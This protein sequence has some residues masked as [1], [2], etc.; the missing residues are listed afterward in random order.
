MYSFPDLEPVC[1]FMSSSSCCF[2][3]CIQISQEAGQVVW[4]S[5]LFKNFT[6]FVVIHTD[7]GFGIVKGA[8]IDL[9]LELFCFF[10]VQWML[11]IWSL[12]PLLFPD[13]AWTSGNLQFT[14]YWS[15]AWRI[16]SITLRASL[17]WV[18]SCGSLNILWHYF[19][20]GLKWKLTFSSPMATAEFSK[21]AGILSATLSQHHRWGFEI[22]QLEFHH[23]H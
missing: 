18:K 12:V 19:S 16:L 3:I 11:A 13:L 4:Y 6:E 20:L 9:F 21:F 10:I 14:Y 1:C 8:E 23:L 15:L 22:A 2:L 5:H 17:R 7:K